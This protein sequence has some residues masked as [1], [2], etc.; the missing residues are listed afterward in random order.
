MA[1]HRNFET[2]GKDFLILIELEPLVTKLVP[3]SL[4]IL[5]ATRTYLEWYKQ[6]SDVNIERLKQA[7]GKPLSDRPVNDIEE[8]EDGI[9]LGNI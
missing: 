7:L 4:R 5:M 3:V 8:R 1:T 9:E 6:K 2:N